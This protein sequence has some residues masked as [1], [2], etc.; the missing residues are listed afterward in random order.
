MTRVETQ[1]SVDMMFSLVLVIKRQDRQNNVKE[2][3]KQDQSHGLQQ[4]APGDTL[5]GGDD[6]RPKLFVCGWI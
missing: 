3:N 2:I 4:T 1:H 6:A 5:Q